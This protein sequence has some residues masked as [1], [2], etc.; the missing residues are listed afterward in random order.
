MTAKTP[1][2]HPLLAEIILVEL[3]LAELEARKR[4]DRDSEMRTS[5]YLNGL[6][7]A[8]KLCGFKFYEDED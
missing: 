2:S 1:M 8:A 7:K 6:R 3:Q 5:I 4:R